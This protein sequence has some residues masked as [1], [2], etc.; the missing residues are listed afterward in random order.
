MK[1]KIRPHNL[2]LQERQKLDRVATEYVDMK[3]DEYMRGF[4]YKL[5]RRLTCAL[6]LALND[7]HGFGS[8]R[9]EWVVKGVAEIINGVSDD[10]YDKNE[11]DPEGRDKMVDNMMDELDDRG[12]YL[13]FEDDP[14]YDAD[15]LQE[16]KR[17]KRER[18]AERN[19]R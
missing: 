18:N 16:R 10:V 5:S 11:L 6:C 8:K 15:S 9:C 14:M 12:I 2:H 4:K 7:Q 3:I 13:V 19:S 1:A 17:R